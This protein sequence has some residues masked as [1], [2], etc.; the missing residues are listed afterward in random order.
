MSSS[1]LAQ[2]WC[3]WWAELQWWW[4]WGWQL[5]Q[6]QSPVARS[7]AGR[8]GRRGRGRRLGLEGNMHMIKNIKKNYVNTFIC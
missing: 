5:L 1:N 8:L 4:C 3:W 2:F 7:A 6:R